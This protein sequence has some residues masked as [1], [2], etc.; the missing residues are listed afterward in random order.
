MIIGGIDSVAGSVLGPRFVG[1][2]RDH[3]VWARVT[4]E[5]FNSA[6]TLVTGLRVS[7]H[8]LV[9]D[10]HVTDRFLATVT[11]LVSMAAPKARH[12]IKHE[13]TTSRHQND[14]QP[15]F[16]PVLIAD[17]QLHAATRHGQ[18]VTRPP[19]EPGEFRVRR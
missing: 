1:P 10:H 11:T 17:H 12:S 3:Q 5:R 9:T 6:W 16:L 15:S 18:T 19:R 8:D 14:S 2:H 4:D 7:G 13:P